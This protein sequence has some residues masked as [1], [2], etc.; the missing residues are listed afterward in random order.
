MVSNATTVISNS[1]DKNTKLCDCAWNVCHSTHGT[2]PQDEV[3]NLC[4]SRPTQVLQTQ[5]TLHPLD[6]LYML[7]Q[8][9]LA[10]HSFIKSVVASQNIFLGS[11]G[12]SLVYPR[13]CALGTRLPRSFYGHAYILQ[14][15]R[16]TVTTKVSSRLL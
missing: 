2:S 6:P 1:N 15:F 14:Y 12:V 5:W 9:A 16:N 7:F 8:S 3:R 4:T 13:P 10:M 11:P